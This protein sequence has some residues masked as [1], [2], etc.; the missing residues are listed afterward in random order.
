[1][2]SLAQ[3]RFSPNPSPLP[4]IANSLSLS[5]PVAEFPNTNLCVSTLLRTLLHFLHFSALTKNPTLLFSTISALLCKEQGCV[6]PSHPLY[7]LLQKVTTATFPLHY[8]TASTS[9]ASASTTT[10]R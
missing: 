9:A 5:R 3:L 2:I 10:A 4:V 7:S 1:M 6:H 8:D